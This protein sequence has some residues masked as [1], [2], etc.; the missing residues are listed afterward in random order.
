MLLNKHKQREKDALAT[1]RELN[2]L[3]RNRWTGRWVDVP[4]F[5]HGWIRDWTLRDDVSR[6]DDA[7]DLRRILKRINNSQW[8][9]DR[10]FLG[11]NWHP[12]R[13]GGRKRVPMD[14][15]R[16]S[17]IEVR[18]DPQTGEETGFPADLKKKWFYRHGINAPYCGCYA[19]R[20]QYYR[21]AHYV[22][23]NP[24]MFELRIRPAF[25]SRVPD[26]SGDIESKIARLDQH[27]EANQYWKLLCRLHGHAVRCR[28]ERESYRSSLHRRAVDKE[29]RLELEEITQ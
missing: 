18:P 17:I 19:H 28:Y 11:Y 15:P 16:L 26:V 14:P 2:E 1:Q 25:I 8:S 13:H 29:T 5:Q 20:Q 4:P 22:F 9:K 10:E 12:N 6:R 23:K 27:M 7:D 3:C 24:W 21:P